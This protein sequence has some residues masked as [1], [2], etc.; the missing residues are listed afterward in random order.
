MP[1][2]LFYKSILK[3]DKLDTTTPMVE[4]TAEIMDIL[5]KLQEGATISTRE[6]L[7]KVNVEKHFKLESR[8]EE[9]QEIISSLANNV[10]DEIMMI[11][12]F[13]ETKTTAPSVSIPIPNITLSLSQDAKDEQP[14]ITKENIASKERATEPTTTEATPQGATDILNKALTL[15]DSDE[16]L[17]EFE[18]LFKDLELL[19][20]T[21]DYK[22]VYDKMNNHLNAIMG[23]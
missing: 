6:E 11:E 8:E 2:R 12:Y 13:S 19:K 1:S 20:D 17:I 14:K 7:N 15:T 10:E 21:P 18:T 22:E 5:E 3:P 23:M 16:D 9:L 4:T